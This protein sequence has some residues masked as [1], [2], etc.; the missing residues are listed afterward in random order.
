MKTSSNAS[1]VFSWCMGLLKGGEKMGGGKEAIN[2]T[3]R[4]YYT[5]VHAQLVT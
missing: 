2:D 5:V 4:E 3:M 1:N